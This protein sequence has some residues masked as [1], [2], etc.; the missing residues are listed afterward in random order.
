V[1]LAAPPEG[2]GR[3]RI[4]SS[5]AIAIG[6][7]VIL[8]LYQVRTALLPFVLAAIPAY[9]CTPL[10]DRLA[11]RTGVPRWLFAAIAWVLLASGG[12]L[13]GYFGVKALAEEWSL[14]G[15]NLQ[16][17]IARFVHDLMGG[18]QL[19]LP[20]GAADS[21]QIAAYAMGAA[22]AWVRETSNAVQVAAW[23]FTGFFG[24]ILV[25]VLLG[26]F[27]VE[28]RQI[29]RGML[30]V[31]PPA[32][33]A[34]ALEVWTRVDPMLRRYFIGVALVLL[35]TTVAAYAGLG[36]VLGLHHAFFLA[37][38]TGVLEVIPV[39]GPVAAAVIAGIAAT[40]QAQGPWNILAYALYATALRVSI[41]QLFGPF[42]L[43]RAAHLPPVLIIFCFLSG[44]LLFGIVGVILAVPV[45]LAV[46]VTLATLYGEPRA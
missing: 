24:F 45:A 9:L 26:Y 42:V 15:V 33:R 3:W 2:S 44:G 7:V 20:G 40:Q 25:W 30:W 22:S 21:A 34:F 14:I 16:G 17:N 29:A 6:V 41:D 36:L 35:Y 38:L 32:Y 11:A 31:V 4:P 1:P 46:K 37:L 28:G 18:R 8:L 39:I 10:L 43:G 19:P 12:S 5:T 13:L 27:L 23:G